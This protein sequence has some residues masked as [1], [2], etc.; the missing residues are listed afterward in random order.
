MTKEEAAVI[1]EAI[2]DIETGMA[3]RGVRLLR[4]LMVERGHAVLPP[5]T[6]PKPREA[7]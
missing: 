3:Y 4:D 2:R 6:L 1:I 7:K 5:P